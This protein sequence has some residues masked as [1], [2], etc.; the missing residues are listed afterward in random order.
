MFSFS[1]LWKGWGPLQPYY[2]VEQ[3]SV[4]PGKGFILPVSQ[5]PWVSGWKSHSFSLNRDALGIT[6]LT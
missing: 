5:F 4:T 3:T 6:Y 2:V 1:I